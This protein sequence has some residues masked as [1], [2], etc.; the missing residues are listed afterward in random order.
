MESVVG[1]QKK[2]WLNHTFSLDTAFWP[3]L[4]WCHMR[5]SERGLA[6]VGLVPHETV[7]ASQEPAKKPQKPLF[8]GTLRHLRVPP[9]DLG[10]H[11]Y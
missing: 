3:G 4:D 1:T 10:P 8:P 5:R 7:R 11:R 2:V 9:H 6:W